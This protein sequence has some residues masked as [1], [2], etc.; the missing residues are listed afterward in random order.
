[1]PADDYKSVSSGGALKLKLKGAKDSK[2]TKKR[3]YN[4]GREGKPAETP[5]DHSVTL[6][7][8]DNE[9]KQKKRGRREA[10]EDEDEDEDGDGEEGIQPDYGDPE[11]EDV[12]GQSGAGS[13]TEAERRYEEQKRKR[14]R[15]LE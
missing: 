9:Q 12:D 1:M 6:K 15:A 11:K 8:L 13:K 5:D 14:V 2:V 3:K 4:S 7:K 10:E